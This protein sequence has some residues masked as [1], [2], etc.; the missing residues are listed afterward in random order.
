MNNQWFGFVVVFVSTIGH[1]KD[2]I[3]NNYCDDQAILFLNTFQ[4][5]FDHT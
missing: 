2:L 3:N 5:L 1:N 4:K